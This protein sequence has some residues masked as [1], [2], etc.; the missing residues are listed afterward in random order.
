MEHC[1]GFSSP[2]N[3]AVDS[4]SKLLSPIENNFNYRTTVR[5]LLYLGL[6]TRPDVAVADNVLG[7]HVENPMKVHLSGLQR[8]LRYLQDTKYAAIRIAPKESTQLAA[9]VDAS[10][11][12]EHGSG[13]QCRTRIVIKYAGVAV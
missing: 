1:N 13:R 6:K 12:G 10:W 11:S 4:S 7:Q 5:S 2:I 9:W 3:R 8:A